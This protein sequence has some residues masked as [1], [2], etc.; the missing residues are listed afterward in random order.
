[1]DEKKIRPYFRKSNNELISLGESLIR[2]KNKRQLIYLK[3][4]ISFRKKANSIKKLQIIREKI[5][6]FFETFSYEEKNKKKLVDK[7]SE[8]SESIKS[9]KED[10]M[11]FRS[12]LKSN[13]EN[14]KENKPFTNSRKIFKPKEETINIE[15][16]NPLV[17]FERNNINAESESDTKVDDLIKPKV[18]SKEI[19]IPSGFSSIKDYLLNKLKN[20]ISQNEDQK[21]N[22]EDSLSE[23]YTDQEKNVLEKIKSWADELVDL[24]G[25][26][27]LISFR[28]TKTTSYIPSD[29]IV[30]SLLNGDSVSVADL[31]ALEAEGN[32]KGSVKEAIDNYEQYGIEVFSLISGFAIWKSEMVSNAYSPLLYYKLSI[33]NPKEKRMKNITFSIKNMEPEVNPALVL[34]LNRRMGEEINDDLLKLAQLEGEEIVRGYLLE[35]ISED[36]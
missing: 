22:D 4:E 24:S 7:S 12:S 5:N 14:N 10:E 17:D 28:Q 13:L 29:E 8:E 33:D 6:I 35:E 16:I 26:N 36:L 20:N 23:K 2:Q 11:D 15:K 31:E 21:E 1:M 25:R 19:I 27:D 34:H 9:R 32:I 18:K 30:E 3:E